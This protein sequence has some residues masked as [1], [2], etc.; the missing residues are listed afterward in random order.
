MRSLRSRSHDLAGSLFAGYHTG[1]TLHQHQ[2]IKY[3]WLLSNVCYK[4]LWVQIIFW[5]EIPHHLICAPPPPLTSCIE[6]FYQNFILLDRSMKVLLCLTTL[7]EVTRTVPV[8]CVSSAVQGTKANR[9]SLHF[10]IT[11]IFTTEHLKIF[12]QAR[13]YLYGMTR[14]IQCT[15][16]FLS[17]YNPTL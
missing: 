17:D 1:M 2:V 16:V 14:S 6:D 3:I 5:H 9:T 15:W 7:T 4:K 10:S 12:P 13:S 11:G 8:G